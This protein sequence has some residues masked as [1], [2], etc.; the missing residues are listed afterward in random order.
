MR[1][2]NKTQGGR[3]GDR[4]REM[5]VFRAGCEIDAVGEDGKSLKCVL[6]AV[7]KIAIWCSMPVVKN[8]AGSDPIGGVGSGG[9]VEP[10]GAP[11]SGF[12]KPP[13]S[14]PNAGK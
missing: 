7:V 9:V 12:E 1:S 8:A 2:R 14:A 6:F 11:M 4:P 13:P 3:R 5:A 10:K